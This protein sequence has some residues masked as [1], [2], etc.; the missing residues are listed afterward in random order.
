MMT[1]RREFLTAAGTAAIMASR[2]GN[3]LSGDQPQLHTRLIPGTSESLPIVG[4]GNSQAFRTGDLEL[5]RHLIEILLGHGGSYIDAG[6]S[7]ALLLAGIMKEKQ[8]RDELFL[9]TYISSLDEAAM[10]KQARGV[11]EAQ[12]GAPL[13]LPLNRKIN[14][15]WRW[16][17]CVNR[18]SKKAEMLTRRKAPRMAYAS[19]WSSP[20]SFSVNARATATAPKRRPTDA[21]ASWRRR[22][23]KGTGVEV[24]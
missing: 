11:I 7:S 3:V 23:T 13:D 20:G 9:G 4:Y 5:S 24:P 21:S 19:G 1:T 15:A 17:S 12:G 14:V 6:G 18:R 2:A 22:K 10:R 8:A 16:N